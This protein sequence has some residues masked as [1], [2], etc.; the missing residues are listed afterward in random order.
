MAR[1]RSKTLTDLEFDIMQ[2]LWSREHCTV[3]DIVETLAKAGRPLAQPSIRTML[4][5]LQAKGYAERHAA[6]R[7]FVYSA[8]VSRERIQKHFVKTIVE[9]IFSGSPLDLVSTLLRGDVISAK[10]LAKVRR[11]IA[12][13]KK[14]KD[15]DSSSRVERP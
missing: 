9:R 14:G 10:D 1:P 8:L 15:D 6:G 13:K 7:G 2:V 12:Q 4:S 11:M 5:I 3:P